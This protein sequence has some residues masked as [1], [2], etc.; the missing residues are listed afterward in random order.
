MD[1][2]DCLTEQDLIKLLTSPKA[3]QALAQSTEKLSLAQPAR[4][5][6]R[7]P[8]GAHALGG[9]RTTATNNKPFADL[10]AQA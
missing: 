3:L 9:S 10:G 8:K 5:Q 6:R 1:H 4:Q 7:N 2:S